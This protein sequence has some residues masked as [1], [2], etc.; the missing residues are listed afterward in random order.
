MLV[1]L[2]NI[3]MTASLYVIYNNNTIMQFKYFCSLFDIDLISINILKYIKHL[4]IKYIKY[5]N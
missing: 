3:P 5:F 2:A 4:N 1:T